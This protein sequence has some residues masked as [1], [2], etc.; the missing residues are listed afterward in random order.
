MGICATKFAPR[1]SPLAERKSVFQQGLGES[2]A[3]D[4]T[5]DLD[6]A[7]AGQNGEGGDLMVYCMNEMETHNIVNCSRSS[8]GNLEH[9]YCKKCPV[10]CV[11]SADL[12]FNK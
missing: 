6:A 4:V 11:L 2:C 1:E 12:D 5:L 10:N 3:R 8:Q 9:W 7:I